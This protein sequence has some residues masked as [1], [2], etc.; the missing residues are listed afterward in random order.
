MKGKIKRDPGAAGK[1]GQRKAAASTPKPA[2]SKKP[3]SKVGTATS[4]IAARRARANAP[5]SS[6][7][8]RQK[9]NIQSAITRSAANAIYNEQRSTLRMQK[10]GQMHPDV[11]KTGLIGRGLSGSKRDRAMA[12]REAA[13]KKVV[14]V[15]RR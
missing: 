4:D 10:S 11:I 8:L 7:Y 9:L 15:R 2:P 1:V 6:M 13:R 3:T 12:N 14:G 5:K